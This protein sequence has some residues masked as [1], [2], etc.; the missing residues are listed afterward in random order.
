M[1]SLRAP[2]TAMLALAL[3]VATQTAGRAAEIDVASEPT[4][5]VA[6]R[7]ECSGRGHWRLAVR[8][9]PGG[10]RVAFRVRAGNP[11]QR[12]NVFMDHNGRGFFAGSRRSDADAMFAVRRVVNDLPGAD[13]FRAGAIDTA[14]GETCRG[15]V[16]A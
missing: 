5:Q 11:G 2:V 16:R 9:V 8:R 10:L 13:R 15:R 1:R 14:S 6:R 3:L 12:W 7:G 4:A